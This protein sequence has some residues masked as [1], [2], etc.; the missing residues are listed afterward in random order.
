MLRVGWHCAARSCVEGTQHIYALAQASVVLMLIDRAEG[1]AR[2]AAET[3]MQLY[4]RTRGGRRNP[5]WV[6]ATTAAASVHY[7]H[8]RLQQAEALCTESPAAAVDGTV[9]WRISPSRMW[10]QQ[11]SNAHRQSMAMP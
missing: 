9:A 5:I 10:S 3:C 7:H 4:A 11:G 6:T 8:N 1:H 2:E